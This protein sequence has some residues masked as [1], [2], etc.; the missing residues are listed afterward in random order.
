MDMHESR[1]RFREAVEVMI[2][3]WTEETLTYHG[4]YTNVDDIWVLPKPMQQPHPPLY[5]AI[6]TEP[7]NCRMGRQ[8][9]SAAH[10][11]RS[12]RYHGTGDERAEDV[13]GK[14]GRVRGIPTPISRRR[15]R[16][17]FM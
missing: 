6:S 15:C 5:V 1:A 3:A 12:H 17:G 10:R 8:P 16:R 9:P 7:G 4:T 14:N 11:G 13:A 2:K